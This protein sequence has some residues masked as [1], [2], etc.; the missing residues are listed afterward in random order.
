MASENL[1]NTV[2]TVDAMKMANKQLKQQFKAINI[3][4][5][6][7]IQ[8]DMAELLEQANEIQEVMGRSYGLSEDIDDDALE[9][10]LDAL[11]EDLMFDDETVPTY[12]QETDFGTAPSNDLPVISEA[13][14]IDLRMVN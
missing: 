7:D 10:E 3:D 9:A 12:L 6:E 5:V 13:K 8:D 1:K 4:K 11:G 14:Q 2:I